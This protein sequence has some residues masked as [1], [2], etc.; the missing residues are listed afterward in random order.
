MDHD[1][2]TRPNDNKQK[3]RTCRIVDFSF[4]IDHRV[5]QNESQKR[6]VYVDLPR[7]LKK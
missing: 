1:Q 4:P 3:M 6:D 5:K 2:M 7:E